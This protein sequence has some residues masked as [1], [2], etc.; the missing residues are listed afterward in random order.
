[1][2]RRIGPPCGPT[3]TLPA[4]RDFRPSPRTPQMPEKVRFACIPARV[5]TS[6]APSKGAPAASVL[7]AATIRTCQGAQHPPAPSS[8]ASTST[9]KSP[10]SSTRSSPT[11]AWASRRRPS[12]GAWRRRASGH[13]S[14][15]V[16]AGGCTTAQKARRFLKARLAFLQLLPWRSAPAYSGNRDQ[17]PFG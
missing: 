2:S 5:A 15:P 1:V 10:A 7:S 6:A 3:A 11:N 4:S 8:T 13:A 16:C 12:R 17:R 14:P 9:S